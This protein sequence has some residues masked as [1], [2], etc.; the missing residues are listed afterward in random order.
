MSRPDVALLKKR[1]RLA[2]YPLAVDLEIL[3]SVSGR[4][5]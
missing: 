4:L 1:H 2:R 3:Q 5:D